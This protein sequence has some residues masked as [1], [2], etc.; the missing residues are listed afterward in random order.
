MNCVVAL[1]APHGFRYVGE[2]RRTIDQR[3]PPV[4][5]IG[6]VCDKLICTQC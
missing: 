6:V 5:P 4:I 2:V 3:V 1:G